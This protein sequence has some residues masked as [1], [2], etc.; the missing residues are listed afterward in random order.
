MVIASLGLSPLFFGQLAGCFDH[1]IMDFRPAGSQPLDGWL[2]WHR[3]KLVFGFAGAGFL[4]TAVQTWRGTP[5]YPVSSLMLRI[6]ATKAVTINRALSSQNLGWTAAARPTATTSQSA[7]WLALPQL[8]IVYVLPPS[9]VGR[10]GYTNQISEYFWVW[11]LEVIGIIYA[12]II[13]A[14]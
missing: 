5:A 6:I 14:W 10:S 3:H 2:A 9:G 11:V 8:A 1:C 4:V 13:G 12:D 7:P